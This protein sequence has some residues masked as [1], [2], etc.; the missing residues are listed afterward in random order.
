VQR[1]TLPSAAWSDACTALTFEQL[2][3]AA[4]ELPIPDV[5]A[6]SSVQPTSLI[7]AMDPDLVQPENVSTNANANSAMLINF[8]A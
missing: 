7:G 6:V 3:A 8:M 2:S 4:T 1:F 5:I